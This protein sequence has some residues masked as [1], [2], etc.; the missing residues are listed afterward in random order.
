MKHFLVVCDIVI[1]LIEYT[2]MLS[3]SL[4]QSVEN[5]LQRFASTG[6]LIVEYA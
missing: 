2:F 4:E 5:L 1:K 3:I 6:D